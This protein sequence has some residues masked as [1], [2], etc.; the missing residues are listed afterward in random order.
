MAM[1]IARLARHA[2]H[3][4]ILAFALILNLGLLSDAHASFGG[5][6]GDIVY[7]N[8]DPQS[9]ASARTLQFALFSAR[10]GQLTFPLTDNVEAWRPAYSPDGKMI[11]FIS[12]NVAG[13]TNYLEVMNADGSNRHIILSGAAF[14]GSGTLYS[15]AWLADGK[16]IAISVVNIVQG[17][18]SS[19]GI[20][21]IEPDGTD[22]RQILAQ[23]SS[24]QQTIYEIDGSP[25]DNSIVARCIYRSDPASFASYDD[26][27]LISDSGALTHIP[28]DFVGSATGATGRGL[29]PPHR[30]PDGKGLI[31]TIG[32]IDPQVVSFSFPNISGAMQVPRSE[33]FSMNLD[34]TGLTELTLSPPVA[35]STGVS[36]GVVDSLSIDDAVM[37]PD[38]TS[39]LASGLKTYP[40]GSGYSALWSVNKSTASI[41]LN[42]THDLYPSMRPH[43]SWQPL[44]N[45]LSITIKDG[46]GNQLKGLKVQLQDNSENPI[47]NNAI[48]SDGG[49][50]TFQDLVPP[51]TY[52]VKAVLTDDCII[53]ACVPAFDVRYAA[54]PENAAD[55]VFMTFRIQVTDRQNQLLLN[56][57]DQDPDQIANNLPSD[58]TDRL[59][60]CANI[61]F[62]LRQYVDWIKA[63]LTPDT[64]PTVQVWTF[65]EDDGTTR[66]EPANDR[67]IIEGTHTPKPNKPDGTDSDFENRDGI[68]DADHPDDGPVN[69]EWHEFT[70]HL[71]NI[72]V[73]TAA[74]V[75]CD[76]G[77]NVDHAG[78]L[79]SNTCFSLDEG[80]AI[81]LPT[82]AKQDIEHVS[83]ANYVRFA[84]LADS[85]KAWQQRTVKTNAEDFA[86]ASL[87]WDLVDN[88][89]HADPQFIFG[90]DGQSH[91]YVFSD[92]VNYP[93]SQIWSLMT[94]SH[95]RTI[96]DVHAMFGPQVPS[97]DLDGDGA[98]DVT[99]LDEVFIMHGFFP[100]D[101]H[102]QLGGDILDYDVAYSE[103]NDSGPSIF[104]NAAVGLSSHHL[105]DEVG[106]L[107][108]TFKDRHNIPSIPGSAVGVTVLDAGGAPLNGATL[109]MTYHH[110]D[111][112]VETIAQPLG[113]GTNIPVYMELPAYFNYP[114]PLSAALPACD[115]VNDVHA[116]VQLN[117]TFGGLVSNESV[118]IDNCA[119]MHAVDSSTQKVALSYTFT[120]PITAAEFTLTLASSGTGAGSLTG[121]GSYPAGQKVTVAA[122]ASAG[123]VFSGWTGPNAAECGTGSVLMTANKSC[124]ATFSKVYVLTLT[125]AGA[126]IGTLLGGGAHSVG[127]TVVVSA[128]AGDGSIFTGWSGAN[129]AECASGSVVMTADKSCVATF[130]VAY[131]LSVTFA[132]IGKGVV[133]GGG[134]Y[135]AGKAVSVSET[136][137][138]GSS[139]T[140]WSGPNAAECATGTVVMT[141]SKSCTANFTIA[142]YTLNLNVAGNG[143]GSVFGAAL[144]SGGQ[145][146]TVL[147]QAN[148]GSVFAGWSGPNAGECATGSV[149][150]NA[151]KSCTATFNALTVSALVGDV[152]GDG[153]VNCAD[154]LIVKN[155]FNTRLGQPK[156]DARADVN[157][158]GVVNIVDLSTVSRALPAGSVCQ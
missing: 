70:H 121:S 67:I 83:D 92:S 113:Q 22:L 138:P 145:T 41:S 80:F 107:T 13:D 115:P 146:A 39:I 37:S 117:V 19:S 17:S 90:A 49:T 137:S 156:F 35:F 44:P 118:T 43:L 158:D 101:A 42:G 62:R 9:L 136:P 78:W 129:A 116:S 89:T 2:P 99:P 94:A 155:A 61:Y 98:N 157:K 21:L 20:Y 40:D 109:N 66:Y 72:F 87:F 149:V 102:R 142:L 38:G 104:G 51:G 77:G 110:P 50:Y 100:V 126:G 120:V 23:G 6:N 3:C 103:T 65:V 143:S 153:V 75:G 133:T 26:Y 53:A 123:S 59:D 16:H 12:F 124:S 141:A 139:F 24:L 119:Y 10:F 8:F 131:T 152:N 1:R 5:S 125:G 79:N 93:L 58:S 147:Q 105:Y 130:A 81:F 28:V 135:A 127:Q 63:N 112:T 88:N 122:V 34:G 7:Q 96:F 108:D 150:M 30:T 86:V 73:D 54:T 47:P 106:K 11:A 55:P 144:Y 84:N 52:T 114:S 46:H 15:V 25:L 111:G 27:C 31:F 45:A 151:N 69:E 132:G 140:A 71:F 32:Y 128:T 74:T 14:D 18:Y 134:F 48:N 4:V 148:S 29:G 33:V 154:L 36:A 68:L 91:P 95:P 60:D 57:S 85:I 97:V 56:F 82:L 76:V 64:G